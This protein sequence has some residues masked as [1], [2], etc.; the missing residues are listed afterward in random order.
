MPKE[1][2][3]DLRPVSK[4]A[5][6]LQ[7]AVTLIAIVFKIVLQNSDLAFKFRIHILLYIIL[8]IFAHELLH[9]IGFRYIGGA[10]W[11]DI[12]YGFNKKYLTPFCTCK[13]LIMERNRFIGVILLPTIILGIGTSII[14]F[15]SSNLFWTLVLGYIFFGGSGD[16]YM[17][18]DILKY[19]K[20]YKFMDHPTEPGYIVYEDNIL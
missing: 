16:I 8:F 9:G 12:R 10:P 7:L 19:S 6:I 2:I 17:A 11:K 1:I 20:T 4:L 15:Y 18:Y 14:T 3:I 13:D 5:V